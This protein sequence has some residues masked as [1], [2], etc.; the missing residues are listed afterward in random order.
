MASYEQIS[1]LVAAEWPLLDVDRITRIRRS[2]RT[3]VKQADWASRQEESRKLA[4]PIPASRRSLGFT[5]LPMTFA[6]LALCTLPVGS[7]HVTTKVITASVFAALTALAT[8]PVS[9]ASI[10]S[11]KSDESHSLQILTVIMLIVVSV[12]LGF[13]SQDAYAGEIAHSGIPLLVTIVSTVVTVFCSV[14]QIVIQI[15]LRREIDDSLRGGA[16]G[17]AAIAERVRNALTANDVAFGHATS[18][19]WQQAVDAVRR[20]PELAALCRE[21][22]PGVG[23]LW[24]AAHPY[25]VSDR[26]DLEDVLGESLG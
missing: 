2:A 11:K 4:E 1:A 8:I 7:M 24:W 20:T 9:V 21:F 26:D 14:P 5:W 3:A 25:Y 6:L 12:V 13:L 10:R 19:E 23:T 17:D 22:G 18:S 15:R 16:A